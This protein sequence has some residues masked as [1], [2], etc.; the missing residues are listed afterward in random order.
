[1]YHDLKNITILLAEDEEALSKLMKDAIGE[2][3]KEFIVVN[4]GEKALQAYEKYKPHIVI[5]DILMPKLNGLEL[6]KRLREKNE[7]LPIILLSAY[8]DTPKLLQAID[9]GVSKYFIKP[10]DPDELLEYLLTLIPKVENM[11]VV[12]LANHFFYNK[13]KKQLYSHQKTISLTKRELDF[14]QLLLGQKEYLADNQLIKKSLWNEA[15]IPNER[16]RTFIRR[17][18]N[19]TSKEFIKNNS[20][21]GYSLTLPL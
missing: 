10:L 20:S 6:L 16:V 3:F 17:L 5:S 1:M 18:R 13:A 19:K 7:K 8:S 4:N 9:N 12:E 2:Y 11:H 14:I 21:L 15:S